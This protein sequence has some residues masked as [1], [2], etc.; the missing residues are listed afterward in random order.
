MQRERY[1]TEVLKRLQPGLV[2]KIYLCEQKLE[3][4]CDIRDMVPLAGFNSLMILFSRG[5]P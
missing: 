1:E 3:D 2:T 5:M 4:S